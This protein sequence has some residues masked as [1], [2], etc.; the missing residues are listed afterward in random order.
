MSKSHNTYIIV[1]HLQTKCDCLG[2]AKKEE[3]TTEGRRQTDRQTD[4][5]I[6]RQA[7]RQAGRDKDRE[8]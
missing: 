1:K 8:S 6:D 5:Q 2:G 4:K 7:G 3:E